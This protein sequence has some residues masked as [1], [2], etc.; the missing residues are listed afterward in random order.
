MD[1]K[2]EIISILPLGAHEYHGPHLP[3]DTDTIIA[4]AFAEA[5]ARFADSRHAISVCP[6]QNIGYSI[7]HMDEEATRTLTFSQAVE[8]WI[9]LGEACYKNGSSKLLILNAHGGNSAL[10]SIVVTELRCRLPMLAVATSWSRF[11][12]PDGLLSAE[13]KHLDIHAGFIETSLMLYLAPETVTMSKAEN[14]HNRQADFIETYQ[15]LRAYGP[16]AF[17]WKMRDLNPKGAAGDA[18]K[19]NADAGKLIFDHALAGLSGLLSDMF[20]FNL[21]LFKQ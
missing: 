3:L 15:Y 16:Q 11:G 9:A 7:E 8:Q 2:K 18:T 12:L 13:E 6:T 10:M 14:F 4:T 1:E 5:L 17:G 20:R 19:A 21:D